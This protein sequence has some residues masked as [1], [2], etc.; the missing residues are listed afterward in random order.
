VTPR[1]GGCS[2]APRGN[3]YSGA[4]RVMRWQRRR[5]LVNSRR[6]GGVAWLLLGTFLSPPL[7]F[8]SRHGN[9]DAASG[10][11]DTY[12]VAPC[13]WGASLQSEDLT[14]LA[15]AGRLVKPADER[16]RGRACLIDRGGTRC[17]AV[18]RPG[19]TTA[20]SRPFEIESSAAVPRPGL[21]LRA[22]F[23]PSWSAYMCR[24]PS[25]RGSS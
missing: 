9:G 12:A 16:R 15:V 20:A 19:E 13:G 10:L 14:N 8:S 1:I 17:S 25:R 7:P 11:A 4:A 18:P 22:R 23:P 21:R 2:I 24:L 5:G 6:V 3:G